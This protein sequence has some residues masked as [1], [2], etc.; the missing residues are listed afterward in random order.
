MSLFTALGNPH[1]NANAAYSSLN[2]LLNTHPSPFLPSLAP[3]LTPESP[4]SISIHTSASMKGK[5]SVE[6]RGKHCCGGSRSVMSELGPD[7]WG[8]A[9]ASYVGGRQRYVRARDGERRR[10]ERVRRVQR[11]ERPWCAG[12]G[13]GRVR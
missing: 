6:L 5:R 11:G 8:G 4:I 1:C 7:T 2:L 13:D 9:R 3:V 12:C 10:V